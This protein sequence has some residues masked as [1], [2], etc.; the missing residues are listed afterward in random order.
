MNVLTLIGLSFLCRQCSAWFWMTQGG[1]RLK[2]TTIY[3]GEVGKRS[4]LTERKGSP[5]PVTVF[6]MKPRVLVPATSHLDQ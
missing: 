5:G 3:I 6:D 2:P 4:R 1:V